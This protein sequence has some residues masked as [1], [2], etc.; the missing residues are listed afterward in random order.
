MAFARQA[1]V[2]Q[3]ARFADSPFA[4]DAVAGLSARPKQIPPKYFYDERGAQLFQAITA[5]PEYYLTSCELAILRERAHEIAKLFPEKSALVELGSG[6]SE[7]AKILLSAAPAIC[8]YVPV[9]ISAQML[10]I[11]A[12]NL[13]RACPGLSVTPVQA[14]FTHPFMLPAQA[15]KMPRNGFFPGST[16][17]NFEPAEAAAFLG[18]TG[19]ILGPGAVMIIGVDL[20]KSPH[21]LDQAYNDAAG[22]TQAFNLNLL[23]RMNRELDADFDLAGFEHSAFYNEKMHRIEMHIASRRRQQVRVADRLIEFEQ[24]ETIHTENSY[25]YSLDSFS[26]LAR[27]SGWRPLRAWTDGGSMFSVHALEFADR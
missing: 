9:D 3:H 12:E 20:I 15:L 22:I 25:K 27:R 23:V 18:Q 26:D 13:R 7:K 10:T 8:A 6:S 4:R 17:G 2:R 11:E 19:R 21:V 24:G 16:I 14:D 5:T 1:A